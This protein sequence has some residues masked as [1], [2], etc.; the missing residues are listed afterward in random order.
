MGEVTLGHEVVCLKDALDIG[1]VNADSNAHEKMLWPL[2]RTTVD[3]Q[4]VRPL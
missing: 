3:L 4:K 1:P 2:G